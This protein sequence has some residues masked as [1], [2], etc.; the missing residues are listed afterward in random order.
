[1]VFI[2]TIPDA[3]IDDQVRAMYEWAAAGAA[4]V[5]YSPREQT[6]YREGARRYT[7]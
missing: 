6:T 5:E 2:D 3:E 7:Y 1:M 4:L